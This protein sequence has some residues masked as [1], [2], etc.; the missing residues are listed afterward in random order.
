MASLIMS[1]GLRLSDEIIP[2]VVFFRLGLRTCP[3]GT[4][5]DSRGLHGLSCRRSTAR[6]QR[7]ADL[8]DIMWRAI[9]RAQ[10]PVA[11][12]PVGLTRRD[13]KRPD[14]ATLIPRSRDKPPACDVTVPGTFAESRLKEMSIRRGAAADGAAELE[15]T[16]YTAVT[17]THTYLHQ[18]KT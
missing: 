4:E 3:C 2:I 1:I 16:K 9:R 6:Q 13:G 15:R 12:Q 14:G 5:V 17:S 11:K 7:H 18:L 10:I 8:N